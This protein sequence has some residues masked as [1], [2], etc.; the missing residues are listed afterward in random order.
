MCELIPMEAVR[1]LRRMMANSP[2]L[3]AALNNPGIIYKKKKNLTVRQAS[4]IINHLGAPYSSQLIAVFSSQLNTPFSSQLNTL[5]SPQLNTLFSFRLNRR[6]EE[7]PHFQ[8]P[9]PI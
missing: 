2:L 7:P 9:I 6:V 4:L 3:E 5:F 8:P 1:S